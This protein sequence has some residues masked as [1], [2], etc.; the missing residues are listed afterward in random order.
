MASEK[1]TAYIQQFKMAH[2]EYADREIGSFSFGN[3]KAMADEL[4]ALVVA[5]IKT[6]TAGGYELYLL[7]G[8]PLPAADAVDVVLDGDGEPRCIVENHLVQVL[9]FGEVTEA[10]AYKEGE[11]DRSL[12][13]WR[14]A[15]LDYFQPI[16]QEELGK[17]FDETSKIVYEEFRVIYR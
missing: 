9:P 15:H 6:G 14:Q 5:G 17:A 11:G 3:T 1:V 4:A 12:A 13:Y 16:Y 2:P 8:A 10:H 7:D